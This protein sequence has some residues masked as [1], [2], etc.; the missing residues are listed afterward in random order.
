MN[1]LYTEGQYAQVQ[2]FIGQAITSGVDAVIIAD[3]GLLLA[4]RQMGW[5]REI[6]VSTGGTT[7][8]NET[9]AFYRELGASRIILPRQ[10]RLSEIAALARAN[11]DIEIE[12]FIMNCGCMNIDGFCTFQHG[13]KEVRL[14][15]WW[16][17]FKRLHWDYY[18]LS[19]LKRLPLGLRETISRSSGITT[20]SAC[21]LTY[22]VALESAGASVA[23][24]AA[25]RAN[26][27]KNFNMF[28]GFDTCG[29]C[30]LW[31]LVQAGVHSVKIV[32]RNN[33]VH[34]KVQDVRFLKSCLR[35]LNEAAP[36]RNDYEAYARRLYRK[37][38][39][40]DCGEWCYFPKIDK[41]MTADML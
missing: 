31:D 28:T 14:P 10:N 41:I 29:V 39:G 12:T 32:G 11:P 27:R 7:F 35:F 34:K 13:V 18:L 16:N 9:V 20:D 5:E 22:D 6:H 37:I 21:F 26:L 8:N 33:P 15:G 25:L 3:L 4:V 40:F 2:E 38:F 19:L 24:Q 17:F 36:S 23:E 1:A 30:G